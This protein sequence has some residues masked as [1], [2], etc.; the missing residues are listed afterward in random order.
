MSWFYF[1]LPLPFQLS[2]SLL[3]SLSPFTLPLLSNFIWLLGIRFVFG[4]SLNWN[5][6][7][8]PYRN[9]TV[10]VNTGSW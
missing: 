5:A 9:G 6:E 1:S 2:L 4:E 7:H 3:L 10:P 8:S